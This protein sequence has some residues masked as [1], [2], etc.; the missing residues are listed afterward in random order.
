MPGNGQLIRSMRAGGG[1]GLAAAQELMRRA[2][3]GVVTRAELVEVKQLVASM[4]EFKDAFRGIAHEVSALL[5]P[6]Q[7]QVF[8]EVAQ[9]APDHERLTDAR[10]MPERFL[11]DLQLVKGEL[12]GHPGL[13]RQ[14]KA[15]RLFA[16]FEGYAARFAQLAHGLKP[17]QKPAVASQAQAASAA[18]QAALQQLA[19]PLTP[20][21]LERTLHQF[22]RALRQAGFAELKGDDGRTGLEHALALLEHATPEAQREARPRAFDA[23][24]WKDNAK[25]ERSLQAEVERER[26]GVYELDARPQ[27]LALQG[28]AQ[29][30]RADAPPTR[31]EEGVKGRRDAGR[32]D[33][34]LGGRMLWNV[35]HLMR[36]EELDDVA[37]KDALTQLAVAAVFLLVFF[38]IVVLV[39]VWV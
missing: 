4:P 33:K 36:G 7:Q 12:L 6:G 3:A 35:L 39:L 18:A 30:Q 1:A 26:R 31:E 8:R 20:P 16:F 19:P 11:S 25:P 15:E 23:P 9:L 14:D 37:K 28:R 34:V 29:P 32:A 24:T 38:G 17:P 2:R 13:S 22:E 27:P 21:E 5:D 10:T